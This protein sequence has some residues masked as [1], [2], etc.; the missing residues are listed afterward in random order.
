MKYLYANTVQEHP[1]PDKSHVDNISLF[2]ISWDC[3]WFFIFTLYLIYMMIDSCSRFILSIYCKWNYLSLLFDTFP[4]YFFLLIK[5][6]KVNVIMEFSVLMLSLVFQV[7][8]KRSYDYHC[9]LNVLFLKDTIDQCKKKLSN[10]GRRRWC[11]YGLY[12]CIQKYVVWPLERGGG[13]VG[14]TQQ[15]FHIVDILYMKYQC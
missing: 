3:S 6:V 12:T 1:S 11:I 13:N 10:I 5:E 9:V 2:F 15:Y 8:Y 7:I 4:L 14:P